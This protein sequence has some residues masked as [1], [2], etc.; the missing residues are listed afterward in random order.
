MADTRDLKSLVK[1]LTYGFE[2]RLRHHLMR[3]DARVERSGRFHYESPRC[4][5]PRRLSRREAAANP[6]LAR[7]TR[8]IYGIMCA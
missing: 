8:A 4:E 7:E 3:A 6:G 1:Y 5:P 2:S